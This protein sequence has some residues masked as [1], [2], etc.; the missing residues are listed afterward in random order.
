MTV[1]IRYTLTLAC[2]DLG[3][4][5]TEVEMLLCLCYGASGC[6]L[7]C[8]RPFKGEGSYVVR[9]WLGGGVGE[10]SNMCADSALCVWTN[11]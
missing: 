4:V 11:D 10:K 3:N 9:G 6:A 8:D 2:F 7:A 5:E 1:I